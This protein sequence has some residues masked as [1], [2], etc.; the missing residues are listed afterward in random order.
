MPL[1]TLAGSSPDLT[2]KTDHDFCAG[3]PIS[4]YPPY[5]YFHSLAC[6]YFRHEQFLCA[7]P[8]PA[9]VEPIN[10]RT[11]RSSSSDVAIRHEPPQINWRPSKGAGSPL[12][13]GGPES[14]TAPI[15]PDSIFDSDSVRN[16]NRFTP[17]F[18]RVDMPLH[19]HAGEVERYKI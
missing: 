9:L 10:A 5:P 11:E 2:P 17:D 14:Y 4:A 19:V 15:S 3:I 12:V 16:I 13:T 7:D 6:I 8:S 18:A 1:L